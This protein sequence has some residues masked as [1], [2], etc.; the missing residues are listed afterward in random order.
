LTFRGTLGSPLDDDDE[1]AEPLDFDDRAVWRNPGAA[2]LH[3]PALLVPD[4][5][6]LG[7]LA[8]PLLDTT[9]S[10]LP[11]LVDAFVAKPALT[12][13]VAAATL[14]ISRRGAAALVTEL[15]ARAPNVVRKLTGGDAFRLY[16]VL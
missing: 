13:S 6:D 1:G 4:S 3:C 14:G 8:T 10:K 9:T 5:D 11:Q 7:T 16:G 12:V 2:T 15:H